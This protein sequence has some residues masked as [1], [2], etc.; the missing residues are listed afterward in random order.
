MRT[1]LSLTA[2]LVLAL[3]LAACGS[4]GSG[5]QEASDITG[6]SAYAQALKFSQ[7]MRSHGVSNFPDP[8]HNGGLLLQ[9]GPGTGIDPR[10]PAFE[11]AQKTCQH[12][13]PK[14]GHP[15]PVSASQRA[16]ALKF[17]QCMRSH[18]VP[19]F[20]DPTFSA[21]GGVRL[22]LKAGNGLDPRS[23]AFQAAQ[24]ACGGPGGG[25]GNPAVFGAQ[26]PSGG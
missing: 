24:K 3:Q 26:P 18:G 5:N 22:A 2:A 16:A 14:G 25:L 9:A 7:C 21:N 15:G 13:L 10:S 23:P 1:R 17:S 6:S 20:P 19:S 12:L 11:S 8:Q 4:G